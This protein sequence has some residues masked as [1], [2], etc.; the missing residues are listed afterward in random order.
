MNLGSSLVSVE[1]SLSVILSYFSF[2]ELCELRVLCKGINKCSRVAMKRITVLDELSLTGD[3]SKRG[4][5]K[6]R[7]FEEAMRCCPDVKT[8]SIVG[9]SDQYFPV[10]LSSDPKFVLL[11]PESF[12]SSP[13]RFIPTNFVDYAVTLSDV[14]LRK[15]L[16]T[17]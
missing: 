10:W 7:L 17:P 12:S 9:F 16:L 11:K 8:I 6:C 2:R 3:I 13:P 4:I 1:D 15:S 5:I 14:Q